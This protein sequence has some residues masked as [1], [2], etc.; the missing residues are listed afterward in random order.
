MCRLYEC[1]IA[2]LEAKK[3]IIDMAGAKRHWTYIDCFGAKKSEIEAV[4]TCVGN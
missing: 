3:S 4:S 2:L 1:Y